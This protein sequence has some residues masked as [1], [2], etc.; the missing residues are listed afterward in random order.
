ML[1]HNL[2]KIYGKTPTPQVAGCSSHQF[3]EMLDANEENQ[4][5]F[6]DRYL[7]EDLKID[8][9]WM[10]AGW[11]PNNGEWFNTGT[12]EVDRKRFPDG[13]RSITDYGRK[14]GIK[15][16]V[17]F[18]PERATPG[19]WLFDN[20]PEWLLGTGDV[21]LVNL[22]DPEVLQWVIERT[23][24]LIKSEG[25]D[26]YR[27]DFNMDPL[28]YWRAN[29]LEDRQGMTEMKHVTN[30]LAWWDELRKRH[31]DM[32]I[33]SCASGGRRNDLETMRR[34]VPLLRSDYIFE[35]IGQQCH[36]Y[37]LAS[38]LPYF[39]TGMIESD[40]Y[41][42]RSLMS[43]NMIS[44]FDMQDPKLD[45][46]AIRRLYN[47]WRQMVPSMLGD[48]YPLTAYSLDNRNWMAW[49]FNR[50]ETGEGV[51]QAFRRA[52]SPFESATFKLSGLQPEKE[53]L[54]TDFN[55]SATTVSRGKD[56]MEKGL[57]VEIQDKPGSGLLIY[58]EKET[59]A[60]ARKLDSG[61]TN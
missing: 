11:Y 46:D 17:W 5:L 49:Q 10:D 3:R 44:C 6:I 23:D 54:L 33:D 14:R 36:T 2:P 39:G 4:K 41:S 8:Y 47:E 34:S 51:V 57:P 61:Y 60:V 13:L 31:P 15:S 37:G 35:P 43:P 38:W 22:G 18:E 7:E 55:T 21:R 16:I 27:N 1:D 32:L 9:W 30:Y 26:L 53:Y 42:Y 58:R 29:D 12:W 59:G 19:T 20:K 52:E 56:L 28:P 40:T 24:S 50:P 45:Y 25:I 48:F